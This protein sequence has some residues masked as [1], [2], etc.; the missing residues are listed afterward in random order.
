ML[1]HGFG[2]DGHIW[3]RQAAYLG[4]NYHLI[5]PDLPGSGLSE[6]IREEGTGMEDYADCLQHIL[7]VENISRCVMIGHSMGGYITLAFSDMYADKLMAWGLFH[8]TAFPDSDEKKETRRKAIGF[9]LQHGAG[10]FLQTSIPG[11]FAD[12]AGSNQMISELVEKGQ[13]F[14]PEAL[15]QYYEAMIRRPDRTEQLMK[16][17]KPVLIILGEHDVAVP[18]RQGLD[19]SYMPEKASVHILRQSAHMGM[20]E[21]TDKANGILAYFL[22]WQGLF[23]R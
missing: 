6:L 23:N 16:T 13:Q 21:E 11:L 2:E 20:L 9:I 10:A 4:D 5:I 12:P 3:D 8:S 18:F 19:Q 14:L 17:D 15:V 1:V 7:D 22:H